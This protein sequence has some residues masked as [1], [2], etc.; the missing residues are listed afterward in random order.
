[1][2]VD[3][4]GDAVVSVPQH[5]CPIAVIDE[6]LLKLSQCGLWRG[7][8]ALH[9]VAGFVFDQEARCQSDQKLS[10]SRLGGVERAR[11]LVIEDSLLDL[12]REGPAIAREYNSC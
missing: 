9:S 3:V 2:R 7:V 8:K 10:G 11:L 1:D 5:E 6:F 12:M 4:G